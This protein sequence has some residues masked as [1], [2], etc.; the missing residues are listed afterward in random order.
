MDKRIF[1]SQEYIAL[2]VNYYQ[3]YLDNE[4]IIR[5]NSGD[6]CPRI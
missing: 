5:L 4:P 3:E 6:T 2:L 1:F